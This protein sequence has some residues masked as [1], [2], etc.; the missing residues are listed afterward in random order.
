MDIESIT[1]DAEARLEAVASMQSELQTLRGRA[2]N[3]AGTVRVEV[4]PA[5]A[6]LDLWL[7]ESV[8]DLAADRLAAEIVRTVREAQVSVADDMR[9]IVGGLVPEDRLAA[10][11]EGRV[12]DSTMRAVDAELAS[13]RAARE[14]ER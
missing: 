7:S 10:L 6:L 8:R 13:I 12:P 11:S 9:R 2:E 4:T 14:Q 5:G 1:R 3:R